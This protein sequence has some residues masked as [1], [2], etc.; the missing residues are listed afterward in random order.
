MDYVNSAKD[1]AQ[2]AAATGNGI[3]SGIT[4]SLSSMKNNIS[5]SMD[6]FS[7]SSVGNAG[8][9]FLN[10]NSI[11]AKFVFLIFVV[12]VFLILLNLGIK[13]IS[14]FT[15][16]SRSPYIVK[17]MVSGNVNATISQDPRNSN[18]A[19]IY[20]SNNQASG[21]EFTWSMW[22]FVQDIPADNNY[23]NIFNKG[24][25]EYGNRNN[26][27][28]V[29]KVNDGPGV[30]L[31]RVG[32]QNSSSAEVVF[33]MNVITPEGGVQKSDITLSIPNFPIQKWCHVIFRLQNKILDSYVNGTIQN[34]VSFE[35]YIPKQNYDNIRIGANGG[36]SG[37]LSNLRY[38]DYAL[39]VFEINS[40]VY[41]GPNMNQYGLS[42][43][44]SGDAK[45]LSKSWYSNVFTNT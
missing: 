17:G 4:D 9:E 15:N 10:S 18:S 26:M 1:S 42:G 40:I 13:F 39:S 8:S 16:P 21:I 36:F 23:K 37:Y 6:S 20:R 22:V 41:Y 31:R 29:D 11:I 5:S 44:P 32:G 19:V 45:Y 14:Y 2:N 3:I 12:G 34:R 38:Y 27:E 33:I 7:S 24:T 25:G 43:K 35:N 28:G 30:Y